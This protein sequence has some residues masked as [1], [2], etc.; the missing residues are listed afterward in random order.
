MNNDTLPERASMKR[1]GRA[2]L[3]ALPSLAALSSLATLAVACQSIGDDTPANLGS[4]DSPQVSVPPPVEPFAQPI[5]SFFGRW[6]G[7]AEDP[8]AIA[9]DEAGISEPYR[10]PSGSSQIVLD[11]FETGG[12]AVGTL[13]FGE[14][15]VP[16]P[17]VDPDVGYP[18]GVDY[19]ELLRY[20]LDS[21]STFTGFLPFLRGQL[22]P[23]E[24]LPYDLIRPDASPDAPVPEALLR[25]NYFLNAV[26][27]EWCNL[28][29]P[30]PNSNIGLSCNVGSPLD[31]SENEG[32]KLISSPELSCD[33]KT[34]ECELSRPSVDLG[35]VDCNKAFLCDDA[36][37]RCICT[38]LGCG[39][40]PDQAE[41]V[42]RLVGD[43]LVGVI[44][45]AAF[46]NERHA[47]TPLG[48]IRFR[49]EP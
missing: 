22:P 23:H 19:A 44:G 48:T 5:S 39:A 38:E 12:I 2:R 33:E 7:V 35:P 18:V 8:L 31:D 26:L 46:L 36:A 9:G 4:T 30:H 13:T 29:T 21:A 3:M 42:V 20:P 17:P 25:V 16:P 34:G 10:F 40:A 43:E 6:V 14:G 1:R 32:C 28:Q 49:R 11:L 24:G 27:S 41:L 45:G 37:P 15:N 47:R